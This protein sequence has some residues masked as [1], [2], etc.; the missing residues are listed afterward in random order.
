[1]EKMRSELV[2][3]SKR[4]TCQTCR[5]AVLYLSMCFRTDL[6]V[7]AI[8]CCWRTARDIYNLPKCLVFSL[9]TMSLLL[10]QRFHNRRWITEVGFLQAHEGVVQIKQPGLRCPIQH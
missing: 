1:M 5:C 4:A 2:K 6:R 8:A 10:E 7:G 9:L 3:K